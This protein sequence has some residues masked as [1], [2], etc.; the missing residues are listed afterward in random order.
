[1]KMKREW[2]EEIEGGEEIANAVLR[3]DEID[4][5]RP[6]SSQSDEPVQ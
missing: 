1:M 3:C 5:Y 6:R 2:K 4:S